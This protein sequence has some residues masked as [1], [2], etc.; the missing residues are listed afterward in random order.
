[1]FKYLNDLFW[2]YSN[3]F[4]KSFDDNKLINAEISS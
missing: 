2:A 1:M 3:E 4:L